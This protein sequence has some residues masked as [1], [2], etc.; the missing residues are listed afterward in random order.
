MNEKYD[1]SQMIPEG[2]AVVYYSDMIGF[3]REAQYPE[4]F[5]IHDREANLCGWNLDKV[6]EV[7]LLGDNVKF[8]IAYIMSNRRVLILVLNS[9]EEVSFYVDLFEELVQK[10]PIPFGLEES[11]QA[12]E[13]FY[14]ELIKYKE[15]KL[16]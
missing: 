1:T 14:K 11:Q 2:I 5:R 4:N 13:K 8:C 6:N 10:I 7:L 12:I 15:K 3:D 9:V 16:L